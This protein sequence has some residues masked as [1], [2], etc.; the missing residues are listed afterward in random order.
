MGRE[1]EKA[2][3]KL[4]FL[5]ISNIYENKIFS[6]RKN[7]KKFFYPFE[8]CSLS[9]SLSMLHIVHFFDDGFPISVKIS[10]YFLLHYTFMKAQNVAIS[11]FLLSFNRNMQ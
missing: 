5:Y 11:T 10:C 7:K 4:N 2:S 3:M 8:R 9:L 1:R 6:H